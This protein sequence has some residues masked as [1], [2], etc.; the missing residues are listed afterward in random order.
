MLFHGKHTPITDMSSLG[1]GLLGAFVGKTVFDFLGL[2][3]GL[4]QLVLSID[5]L[6]A[7]ML[8]SLV[9]LLLIRYIRR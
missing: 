1:L 3:L 2:R 6:V 9:L 4:P 8:G 5:D 7:A